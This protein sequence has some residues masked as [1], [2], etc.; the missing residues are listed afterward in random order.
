MDGTRWGEP[1]S[2]QAVEDRI[3]TETPSST[4]VESMLLAVNH[5]NIWKGTLEGI[6]Y[7]IRLL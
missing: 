5:T 2:F 3:L 7:Y 6:Q 4:I 1:I